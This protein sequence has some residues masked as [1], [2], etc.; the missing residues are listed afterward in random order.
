MGTVTFTLLPSEVVML[1][2]SPAP[3][4]APGPGRPW[5]EDTHRFKR[6]SLCARDLVEMLSQSESSVAL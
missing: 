4:D 5:C 6:P 1:T 2:I 3:T